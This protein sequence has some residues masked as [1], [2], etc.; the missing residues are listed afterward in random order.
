MGQCPHCN[1]AVE[2]WVVLP[3]RPSPEDTSPCEQFVEQVFDAVVK[4]YGE[5]EARRI[6]GP[7]GKPR[8]KRQKNIEDNA[9]LA[10]EY[11]L[12]CLYAEQAKRKP[13]VRKLARR[14]AKEG[15]IDPIAMEQR[16]WRAIKDEKVR[17]YLR[18]H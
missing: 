6:F 15:N 7:Y 14:L 13:N 9:V 3:F 8:T 18:E 12:E 5:D 2:Y 1:S 16:I 17:R 4:H 11:F 10:G